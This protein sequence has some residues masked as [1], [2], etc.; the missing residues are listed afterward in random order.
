M[1]CRGSGRVISHLGGASTPVT[2]PWCR[3]GGIR[4]TDLDAQAGWLDGGES[5]DGE[6]VGHEPAGE[7]APTPGSAPERP[8]PP[9]DAA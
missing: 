2:C 3:G 7:E 1:A 9:G 6:P 4:L 5:A 8:E